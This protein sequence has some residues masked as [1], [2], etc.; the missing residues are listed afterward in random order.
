[1][2][3]D[4]RDTGA[5][6]SRAP[7][8]LQAEMSHSH[9]MAY[10]GSCGKAPEVGHNPAVD[11]VYERKWLCRR[12]RNPLKCTSQVRSC[13]APKPT[14]RSAMCCCPGAGRTMTKGG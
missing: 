11:Q 14:S 1:Q 10:R 13:T 7:L 12:H 6:V 2:L 4:S 5:P 3:I 8:L 9:F